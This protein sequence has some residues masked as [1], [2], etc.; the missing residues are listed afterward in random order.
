LKQK[1]QEDLKEA[2]MKSDD[3]SRSVLRMLSAAVLNKEKEKRYRISK[4]EASLSEPELIKKSG[5]TDEEMIEVISYEVKK[6]KESITWQA[7]KKKR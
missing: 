4:Q 7:R 3:L 5:L 1:I 6:R 2:V